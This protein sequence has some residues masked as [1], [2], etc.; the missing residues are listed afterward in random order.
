[1][2]SKVL[3]LIQKV[4][5][6]AK[7]SSCLCSS[8][9]SNL[10]AQSLT[11]L[12]DDRGRALAIQYTILSAS[13][14]ML[15]DNSIFTGILMQENCHDIHLSLASEIVVAACPKD[16]VLR[17]IDVATGTT[18][19]T[20]GDTAASGLAPVRGTQTSEGL[21]TGGDYVI[22]SQ[23]FE[24]ALVFHRWG[25]AQPLLKCRVSESVGPVVTT[26]D[27]F[28]LLAGGRSGQIYAWEI[29]SGSLVANWDAHYKA[30]SCMVMTS[31]GGFLITGSEDTT[32]R[33]WALSDILAAERTKNDE[34][35]TGKRNT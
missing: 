16:R 4:H 6:V 27:G 31:D 3:A 7:P 12:G 19:S 17:V 32:V 18:Y 34:T 28:F 1:M 13:L 26:P 5:Q 23:L 29:A 25:K 10:R 22:S 14:H 24:Q 20:F 11:R 30:V 9:S 2:H 35:K 33:A 15:Y 8:A 21:G